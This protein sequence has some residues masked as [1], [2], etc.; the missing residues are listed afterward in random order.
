MKQQI[1]LKKVLVVVMLIAPHEACP[2]LPSVVFPSRSLLWPVS[3][4]HK[5]LW[6]VMAIMWSSLWTFLLTE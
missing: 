2:F 3:T 4:G 5:Q 6:L 1:T